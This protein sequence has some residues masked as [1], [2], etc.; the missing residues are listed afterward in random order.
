MTLDNFVQASSHKLS[1]RRALAEPVA[2][3]PAK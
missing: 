1:A 2:P 3:E